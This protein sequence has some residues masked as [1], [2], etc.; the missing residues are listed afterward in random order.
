MLE[1]KYETFREGNFLPEDLLDHGVV[2]R[3]GSLDQLL[4][5]THSSTSLLSLL[6]R[7]DQDLHFELVNI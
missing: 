2:A 7:L 3:P 5:L 6:R 4:R 1:M